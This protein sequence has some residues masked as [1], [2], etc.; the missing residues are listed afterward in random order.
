MNEYQIAGGEFDCFS[1]CIRRPTNKWLMF[2][3]DR[4]VQYWELSCRLY[5]FCRSSG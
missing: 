1:L 5:S 3:D 4:V 2:A